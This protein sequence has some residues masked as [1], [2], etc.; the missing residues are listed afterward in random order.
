MG[1]PVIKPQKSGLHPAGQSDHLEISRCPGYFT[2]GTTATEKEEVTLAGG[3]TAQGSK[4]DRPP[5][6]FVWL[7]G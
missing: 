7:L 3:H 5:F 1:Q 6:V 2:N 4:N